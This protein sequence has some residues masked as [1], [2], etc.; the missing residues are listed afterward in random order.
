LAEQEKITEKRLTLFLGKGGVGKTTLAAAWAMA[1]SRRNKRV[2]LAQVN[3]KERLTRLLGVEKITDQVEKVKD[4]LWAVN[5]TPEASLHEYGLMVLRFESVYK[6]VFENK[7][8]KAFLR[9]VPGLDDWTMLGKTWFHEQEKLKDQTDR[10]DHIIVDCPATG[11]G[12]IFLGAPKA[13]A[14]V[15]PD[16]P[17]TE[18][19]LKMKVMLEDAAKTHPV[20]VTLPEDMPYNETIELRQKIEGEVGL[21]K[22][23]LVINAI[24]PH[25]ITG[26][27][28]A[29][30]QALLHS[31]EAT[32]GML[33]PF[34]QAAQRR[35]AR[36]H[37][38]DG[39]IQKIEHS[40]QDMHI[41]K[42]PFIASRSFGSKELEQI[43]DLLER[44]WID[45]VPMRRGL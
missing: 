18:Y 15:S 9:A 17:L 42:T 28:A 12:V 26:D 8:S 35:V 45:R 11:H 10:F 20:Y 3:A 21:P 5:M 19:A 2:L 38:Q 43:A 31:D 29:A 44:A 36:R 6:L 4:N 34:L 27:T 39:Y 40:F 16:G 22:G 41:T 13:V 32:Q 23:R 1:L 33:A 30:Y 25:V 24:H 7:M 14:K 37:L